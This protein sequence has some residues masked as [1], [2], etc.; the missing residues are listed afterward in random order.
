MEYMIITAGYTCTDY[1]TNRPIAK[2]LKIA[3]I[4][5]KLLEYQKNWLQHVK[6]M[7]LNRL[8]RVMKHHSPTGRRYQGRPLKRI[9]Y[10]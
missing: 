8:P 5:K 4:L 6:R 9:L 7:H 10:T 2:E 3:S 1:K